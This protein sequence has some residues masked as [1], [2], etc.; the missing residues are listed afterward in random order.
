M[1]HETPASED[2]ALASHTSAH[3]P[4]S[5]V[6]PWPIQGQRSGGGRTHRRHSRSSRQ[7]PLWRV[8]AFMALLGVIVVAIWAH[9]AIRAKELTVERAKME[10]HRL[11]R[12]RDLLIEE[13]DRLR[14]EIRGLVAGRLPGVRP[15]VFDQTTDL[16]ESYVRNVLFSRTGRDAQKIYEYRLMIGNETLGVLRPKV[17]V[18]L[19]DQA[20]IQVGE[21]EVTKLASTIE[22]QDEFLDPGETRAYSATIPMSRGEEPRYFL[23]RVE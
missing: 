9:F 21:A 7:L 1:N 18:L 17:H 20:G 4:S 10:M 11:E 19:F 13:R 23:V 3:A 5:D 16:G 15:L 12:E 14:G 2:D 8:G 22:D 6:A